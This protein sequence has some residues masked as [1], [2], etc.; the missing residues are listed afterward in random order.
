MTTGVGAWLS[1][2]DCGSADVFWSY[3]NGRLHLSCRDCPA[4]TNRLIGRARLRR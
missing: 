1:C 4:T 2:P 3:S